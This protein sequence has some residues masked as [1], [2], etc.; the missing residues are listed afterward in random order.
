MGQLCTACNG[1][2]EDIYKITP[3]SKN[4][5]RGHS[6]GEAVVVY[7]LC[8]RFGKLLGLVGDTGKTGI[9]VPINQ[10]VLIAGEVVL[11]FPDAAVV[12]VDLSQTVGQV[13]PLLL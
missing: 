5:K 6:L 10:F 13:P 1:S 8:F 3:F 4:G 11:K 2:A 7:Y 12:E 9:Y